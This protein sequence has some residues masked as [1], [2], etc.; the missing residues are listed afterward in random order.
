MNGIDLSKLS[1]EQL[2]ELE[3]SVTQPSTTQDLS[4]LSDDE[5]LA[6]EKQ[7]SGPLPD[8][9]TKDQYLSIGERFR[10]G[11]RRDEDLTQVREQQRAE[12]GLAPGT[13]LEP[14]GFNL[15]NLLDLPGDI[16]DII[17]KALPVLGAT[18]GGLTAGAAALPTGPGALL[19]VAKGGAVGGASGELLRQEIGRQAF[20]FDQGE[21]LD[22]LG[23]IALEGA[24]GAGQEV[25]GVFLGRALNATKLGML[26]TADKLLKTK[27]LE[28]FTKGFG[29]IVTNVDKAKTNFAL[30]AVKR[31]DRRVLEKMFA[32]KNF[33]S[34]FAKKL[35]VGADD[36]VA[37]Q[38]YKLAHRKGSKDAV[39]SL[40]QRFFPEITDDV[41][42][43]MFKKGSSVSKYTNPATILDLGKKINSGMDDLFTQ[44]GK[45]LNNARLDLVKKAGGVDVT[46]PLTSVNEMLAKGL[47]DIGFLID[48]GAGN[49]S[50]NPKFAVTGTGKNQ[51]AMFGQLVTRFFGTQG[52]DALVKAAQ[53]G[54]VTALMKLANKATTGRT[55]LF[56]INNQMKFNKFVDTLKTLDVQ[57]SGS[58]F[59]GVGKLSPQLTEYLK[60]LRNIPVSVEQQIGGGQ[61]GALTNAFRELAE[62]A[63]Q[64][65]N[66]T[67]IK[68][69]GQIEK[70]LTRFANA[71][72]GTA[73]F[74]EAT[75]LNSFLMKNLKVNFLDELKGFKA[76][77]VA[78]KIQ[79]PFGMERQINSL[80]SVMK[81]AFGEGPA[82]TMINILDE[83]DPFLPANLRVAEH[84]RIHTVAEALHK[85]AAS[86]LRAKFLYNSIGPAIAG[87]A[88]GG[89]AGAATG[90]AIGL[91]AQQPGILRLLIKAA[92]IMSKQQA[93]EFAGL[94]IKPL[95][96]QVARNV[97][98]GVRLLNEMLSAR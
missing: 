86:I 39:K 32:D 50:I 40:Y 44:S 6:F 83:L 43:V 81:N 89:P 94:P 10:G 82:N 90:V 96:K 27:G 59:K 29:S 77:Q 5:L 16:A 79:S 17:G 20:G 4:K 53:A 78:K 31:G 56:N 60:G 75:Q 33:A 63:A 21:I 55:K 34:D 88:I 58:E 22:R 51:A 74:E 52:D 71:Q 7:V 41:F 95:T 47:K 67:K 66:G 98:A 35:F 19:G 3:R 38:L 80:T 64:L 54:D 8:K 9:A 12:R 69:V 72:P 28:G 49:F 30:D 92:A 15:E 13:P 68:N 2:L 84:A 1:D 70:A 65:R 14:V 48:E 46:Q 85:D 61:V 57:I 23:D 26:K 62:G 18:V 93:R 36:D 73:A 37:K 45:Q 91:S 24:K 42:D 87:G 25:G 76:A 97:P 11:F